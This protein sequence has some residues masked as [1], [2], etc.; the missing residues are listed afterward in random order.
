MF[1]LKGKILGLISIALIFVIGIGMYAY[2][3]LINL[4]KKVEETMFPAP[5][6]FH[7][8]RISV[9][10]NKLYNIFLSESY[11]NQDVQTDSLI[12]TIHLHLDSLKT[13]LTLS[14]EDQ[15]HLEMI[16]RIPILLENVNAE[17]KSLE[18]RRQYYNREF[19]E[20]LENELIQGL[21]SLSL[22]TE[23]SITILKQI[24]AEINNFQ[25]EVP[26]EPLVSNNEKEPKRKGIFQRIFGSKE[27]TPSNPQELPSRLPDFY[28]KSDT[29]FSQSSDTLLRDPRSSSNDEEQYVQDLIGNLEERRQRM[30]NDLG[31][32]AGLIYI[33]NLKINQEVENILNDLLI[34][35]LNR[36][37]SN[38][39]SIKDNTYRQTLLGISLILAFIGLSLFS[40]YLFIR[41]INKNLKYQQLLERNEQLARKESSNKQK[42]LAM[43]SHELRTPLTS[44]IGYAELLDGKDEKVK[45]IRSASDYLY[46][47][48]NEVLDLAKMQADIIEIRPKPVDITATFQDIQDNFKP[49][50]EQKG[51]K[52][53]FNFPSSPLPIKADA[54][55]LHQII[56]NLLHNAVKFT[57]KGFIKLQVDV[58]QLPHDKSQ[59]EIKIE[60]S[61]IG[62]SEKELPHIFTDFQQAGTHID[63]LNGTGLGLGIVKKV[64]QQMDGILTVKSE[65]GKGTLFYLQF[66]FENVNKPTL[67]AETNNPEEKVAASLQGFKVY[68]IDDDPLITSL[69]QNILA[70]TGASFQFQND[71]EVALKELIEQDFD[72]V[73]YDYRLG[74]T[75]G[76]ELYSTLKNQNKLPKKNI[77]VTANAMITPQEEQELKEFDKTLYKPIKKND[78]LSIVYDLLTQDLISSDSRQTNIDCIDK[79]QYSLKDLEELTG[80]DVETLKDILQVMLDEN[81]KSL[82]ALKKSIT[83]N[84]TIQCGELIHKMSS[85]FAQLS[86]TP[87]IDDRKLQKLLL[88]ENKEKISEAKELY[89][90]WRTV[91]QQIRKDQ[92]E[93]AT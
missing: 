61:G 69:Y 64:V 42:F 68:A 79:T 85:R 66:S 63:N 67:S 12:H 5:G 44:I 80:G 54:Y 29:T 47:M 81:D 30:I 86:V 38:V 19:Y 15:S 7:L 75:N 36:F 46:R 27:G 28:I 70:P 45:A 31:Q 49:L 41:D 11:V 57:D 65:P 25:I 13:G 78:L 14:E 48:T 55:R 24:T 72:L 10:L 50:I 77:I 2:F 33:E 4:E 34:R 1:G 17:Y 87:P 93:K 53:I 73:I 89:E 76:Y 22:S 3:S 74:N 58:V 9:N 32:K 83:Q 60:D 20:Y 92:L 43:M 6:I 8:K 18:K 56:Y 26:K 16:D 71:P 39:Q 35:E 84:D 90:Y 23:D 21:G 62:I 82:K 51:L 52:P 91:N 40:L 59:L 88:A 37:E